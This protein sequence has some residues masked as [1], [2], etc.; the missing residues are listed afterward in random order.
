[1]ESEQLVEMS[2]FVDTMLVTSKALTEEILNQSESILKSKV[3]LSIGAGL[4]SAGTARY[5]MQHPELIEKAIEQI[6]ESFEVGA[7]AGS[8][9]AS[10]MLG[11]IQ[12]IAPAIATALAGAG[13][14]GAATVVPGVPPPP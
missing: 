3:A 7:T 1:M 11:M 9:G 13:A 4:M 10:S 5:M 14:V 6:G 8:E 12:A 2:K